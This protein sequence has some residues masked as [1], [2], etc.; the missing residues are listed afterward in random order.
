M[1]NQK[2]RS[3]MSRK[4]TGKHIAISPRDIEIFQ[5]LERYRYLRS[6][7]LYALVG[8]KSETRFKERLGDLYHEGGYI[9]RPKAQWQYANARYMPVIY[10]LAA[11]GRDVLRDTGNQSETTQL[12]FRRSMGAHHQFAHALMICD[13]LASIELGVREASNLRFIPWQEIIAK[14]PE[15][16]RAAHNPLA[17]PV[18]VSHLSAR[19]RKRHDAKTT[20]IPDALFG[21]EYTGSD[22][23]KRY[24]FFALEA[25]RNTIPV[26]RP[27]LNQS[28]YLKKLLAYRE[29]AARKIYTSHLGIPN[30]MVLTVTTNTR[31]MQNIME[32]LLELTECGSKLFLF[33]TMSAL[34]DFQQAPKPTPHMLTESW[35]RV[36]YEAFWIDRV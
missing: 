11:P 14:A 31:H 33:K 21:L 24:R 23:A 28:S 30:L 13:I 10:E 35:Q 9:N 2:R 15:E 5:L 25:D 22:G 18:S 7:F 12:R 3:R 17:L 34:G 1:Q 8:G 19:T 6:T 26:R 4:K 20:L 36:G 32:L 16:T 29:I 27:N